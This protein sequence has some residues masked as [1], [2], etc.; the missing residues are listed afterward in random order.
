MELATRNN[1]VIATV[2]SWNFYNVT[3]PG[4]MWNFDA[5]EKDPEWSGRK[6][7]E[8]CMEEKETGNLSLLTWLAS[9]AGQI[10]M[11]SGGKQSYQR[12]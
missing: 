11:I 5:H 7:E 12:W 9:Q 10:R 3:D 4:I 2:R 6:E 1:C 8:E